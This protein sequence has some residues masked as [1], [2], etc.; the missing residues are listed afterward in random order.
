MELC[1]LA[2]LQVDLSFFSNSTF[3]QFVRHMLLKGT[4]QDHTVLQ[5]RLRIVLEDVTFLD[6]YN[7]SGASGLRKHAQKSAQQ[8]V[9]SCTRVPQAVRSLCSTVHTRWFIMPYTI[10]CLQK[11]SSCGDQSHAAPVSPAGRILNVAVCAADTNEPPRLLNY[12]TAPNVVVWSA[13]ACSSAFPGLFKPQ[14]LLAKDHDGNFVRCVF[15]RIF[16]Q[17]GSHASGTWSAAALLASV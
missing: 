8:L 5:K 9:G 11:C 13:V 1:P 6:A 2:R 10:V 7:K 14:D 15:D 4:L 3:G 12:L 17:I 16:P